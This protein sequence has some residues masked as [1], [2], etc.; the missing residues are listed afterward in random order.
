MNK[1]NLLSIAFLFFAMTNSFAQL[2]VVNNNNPTQLAQVL[3]GSGVTVSNAT[4]NCPA[5]ALG[6][7]NNGNSTGFLTAPT[8]VLTPVWCLPPE[9]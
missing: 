9:R 1:K 4:I 7:F 6:T 2:T 3:A 8:W 5:A